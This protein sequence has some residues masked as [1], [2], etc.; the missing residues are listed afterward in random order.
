MNKLHYN[1]TVIIGVIANALARIDFYL[2]NKYYQL[3][4]KTLEVLRAEVEK[5]VDEADKAIIFAEEARDHELEK[6]RNTFIKAR[7]SV[8]TSHD[9]EKDRVCAA[10]NAKLSIIRQKQDKLYG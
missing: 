6:V 8:Y 5:I 9:A 7:D 4:N 2:A 10:R 1:A 3:R